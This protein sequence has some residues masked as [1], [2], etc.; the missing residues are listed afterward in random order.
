[1]GKLCVKGEEKGGGNSRISALQ[2][3][4]VRLWGG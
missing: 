4:L 3:R 1:M 2:K